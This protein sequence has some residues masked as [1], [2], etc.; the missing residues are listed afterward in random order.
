MTSVL[1]AQFLVAASLLILFAGSLLAVGTVFRA[2]LVIAPLALLVPWSARGV[3][4]ESSAHLA[5]CAASTWAALV[6]A[7]RFSGQWRTLAIMLAVITGIATVFAGR[8]AE[9]WFSPLWY[10]QMRGAPFNVVDATYNRWVYVPVLAALAP[11][12]RA[13]RGE[14]W[15]WPTALWAGALALFSVVFGGAAYFQYN[16]ALQM[17]LIVPLGLVALARKSGGPESVTTPGKG[18]NCQPSLQ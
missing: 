2:A 17:A 9:A 7:R 5:L 1:D 6:M 14:W 18:M 13:G 11:M 15:F 4:G 8:H 16:L 3:S 12:V 10:R